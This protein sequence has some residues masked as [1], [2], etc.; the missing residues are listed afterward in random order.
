MTELIKVDYIFVTLNNA[1][2]LLYITYYKLC[3][4]YCNSLF[5]YED[6]CW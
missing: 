1:T 5:L 4:S 6:R 2:Y 3:A